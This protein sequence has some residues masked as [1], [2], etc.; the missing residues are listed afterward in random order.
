MS[1]QNSRRSARSRN[2]GRT[3]DLTGNCEESISGYIECFHG[4]LCEG[5]LSEHWFLTFDDARETIESWRIDHSQSRPH[6][7]SSYLTPEEFA[8]ECSRMDGIF[9]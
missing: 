1:V 2:A 6:S 3:P 4:K 5:C 9:K 7:S 8:T